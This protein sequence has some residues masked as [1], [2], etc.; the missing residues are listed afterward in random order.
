MTS[1]HSRT[2]F[3]H[4]IHRTNI[5]ILLFRK[6]ILVQF[7][8]ITQLTQSVYSL[9]FGEIGL[10]VLPYYSGLGMRILQQQGRLL[11]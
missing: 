1:C 3:V 2:T 8:F 4:L 5:V 11:A 6:V 9:P 10:Y 7:Q